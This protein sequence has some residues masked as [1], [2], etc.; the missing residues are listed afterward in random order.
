MLD[1]GLYLHQVNALHDIFGEKDN[2]KKAKQTF[3]QLF[4]VVCSH[5]S[6]QS[7]RDFLRRSNITDYTTSNRMTAV[8]HR[9]NQLCFVVTCHTEDGKTHLN[10]VLRKF[11]E[12]A[13]ISNSNRKTASDLPKAM[14][15]LLCM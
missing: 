4:E 2:G 15:E 7:E 3:N 1:N 12:R 10:Q 14:S 13:R 6:R 5:M 9:G 11:A 8:E